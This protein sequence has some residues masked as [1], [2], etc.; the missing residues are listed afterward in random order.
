MMPRWEYLFVR[1]GYFAGDL[2]AQSVNTHETGDININK[3]LHEYANQA[4]EEG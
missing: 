1:F 2:R 3:P 4:R